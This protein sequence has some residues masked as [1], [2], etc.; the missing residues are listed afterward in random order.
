MIATL[1]KEVGLQWQGITLSVGIIALLVIAFSTIDT[2]A[3]LLSFRFGSRY[4]ARLPG[5]GD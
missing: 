1:K 2:A 3:I 4:L 5:F